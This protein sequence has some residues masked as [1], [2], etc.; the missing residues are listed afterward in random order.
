MVGLGPPVAQVAVAV[1]LGAWSSKPWLISM[2][3]HAA[4]G[5]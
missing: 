1:V 4:D 5:A 3:D 2:A